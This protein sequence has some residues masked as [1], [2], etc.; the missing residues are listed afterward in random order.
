MVVSLDLSSLVGFAGLSA[1]SSTSRTAARAP[2]APETLTP[3]DFRREQIADD[4]RVRRALE[5]RTLIVPRDSSFDREGVP[6]DH[7]KLFTLYNALASLQALATA[8]ADPKASPNRF[9]ALQKR[10]ETGYAET[11]AFANGLKLETLTMLA[12]QK[13]EQAE[14][15]ATVA[16]TRFDFTTRTLVRGDATAPL[17]ALAA[18]E[19]FTIR[20]RRSGVDTDVTIDLAGMGATPRNLGEVVRYVNDQLNAAGF[21]PG[22]RGSSCRSR[23]A[24]PG[25]RSPHRSKNTPSASRLIRPSS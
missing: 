18:A 13:V 3:W 20:V 2:A 14:T 6:E 9:A 25:P 24:R 17:P 10:F 11:L 23:R 12:G 5:A 22:W 8:A 19:P 1:S 21:S 4:Q 7:K 15:A 16:R